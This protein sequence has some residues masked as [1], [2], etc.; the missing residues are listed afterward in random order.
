MSNRNPG[1]V[2]AA[3]QGPPTER[4]AGFAGAAMAWCS[5]LDY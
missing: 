1:D 4:M 3:V 2:I 5:V